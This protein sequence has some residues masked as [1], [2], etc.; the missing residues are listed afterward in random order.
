V[1]RDLPS[2]RLAVVDDLEALQDVYRRASLSNERDRP[3]LLGRPELLVLDPAGVPEGRTFAA[4]DGSS[5]VGSATFSLHPDHL[6]LDGLFVHPDHRRRGHALRLLDAVVEVARG[7]GVARLEV[8]ANDHA[9]AFYA[10]A[11]FVPVGVV[12][13]ELGPAPRQHRLL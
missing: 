9:A 12:E 6:E 2:V 5:V 11:G 10:A 1:S 3:K 8:T 4:V 13:T 7:A